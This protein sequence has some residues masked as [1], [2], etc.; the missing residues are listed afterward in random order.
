MRWGAPEPAC[1][2]ALRRSGAGVRW[3]APE[4]ACGGALRS[5]RAVGRS[6]ATVPWGAPEPACGGDLAGQQRVRA[7]QL[8]EGR[9]LSIE[10]LGAGDELS[11]VGRVEIQREVAH[12][13]ARESAH[14]GGDRV[15]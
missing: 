5:Q 10:T 8:D 13:E 11:R 4:P 14:L 15:R 2:G 7:A 1:G 9:D 3:G 12:P 6:G